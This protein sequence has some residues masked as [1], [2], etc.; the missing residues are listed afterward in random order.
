MMYDLGM[1]TL[2]NLRNKLRN[3]T[4]AQVKTLSERSGMPYST[5]I[6]VRNGVYKGAR[7]D[8]IIKLSE[9]IGSVRPKKN[10]KEVVV[11]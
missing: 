5:L 8:T 7:Y 2:Q 1:D 6:K 11:L 4:C 9:C 3:L 10:A